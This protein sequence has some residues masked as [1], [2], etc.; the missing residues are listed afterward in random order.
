MCDALLRLQGFQAIRGLDRALSIFR[1]LQATEF[2]VGPRAA[3]A[4]MKVAN[5]TKVGAQ[6]VR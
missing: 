2:P 6:Q 4:L 3:A 5:A 1:Q